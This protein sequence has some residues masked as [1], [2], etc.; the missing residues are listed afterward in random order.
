MRKEYEIKNDIIDLLKI[1]NEMKENILNI[2]RNKNFRNNQ[3]YVFDTSLR[4]KLV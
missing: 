3:N 4:L 2:F 1:D